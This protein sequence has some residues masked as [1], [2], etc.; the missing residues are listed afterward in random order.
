MCSSC[1][2]FKHC[3][4]HF[5]IFTE[6]PV[7]SEHLCQIPAIRPLTIIRT[8]NYGTAPPAHLISVAAELF[9]VIS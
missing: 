4:F 5:S 3:T 9:S 1:Y 8:G 7:S 2:A 6:D